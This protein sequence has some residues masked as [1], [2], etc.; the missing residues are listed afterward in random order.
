MRG[1]VMSAVTLL[2]ALLRSKYLA[3]NL[4]SFR[5]HT[6]D[7]NYQPLAEPKP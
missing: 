3:D 5:A 6:T 2:A 4:E 1:L 7:T